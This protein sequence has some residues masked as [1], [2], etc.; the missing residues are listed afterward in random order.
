MNKPINSNENTPIIG[1]QGGIGIDD[2]KLYKRESP[3]NMAV[4]LSKR[5]SKAIGDV[6]VCTFLQMAEY[7][8][9]LKRLTD[10]F[11]TTQISAENT[12]GLT[13][14]DLMELEDVL[15]IKLL[16]TEIQNEV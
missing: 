2:S 15:N 10:G 16:I 1:S 12:L 5:I 3:S 8:P 6:S 11:K 7:H 14:S 13:V 4:P 9:I